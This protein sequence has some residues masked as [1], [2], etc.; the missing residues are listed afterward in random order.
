MS[1]IRVLDFQQSQDKRI[2]EQ[3]AQKVLG[4]DAFE[5]SPKL[6]E[7]LKYLLAQTLDGN[8][9]R[10]KQLTIAI[11]V[12]DRGAD[13]DHQTDPIVRIQAG[14]LRRA[15]ENYYLKDGRLDDVLIEIPKGRYQAE[16]SL[17]DVR[18][19][20][21]NPD[22]PEAELPSLLQP[23]LVVL[24]FQQIGSH[25]DQALFS[26]GFSEQLATE[27]ARFDHLQVVSLIGSGQAGEMTHAD[28]QTLIEKQDITFLVTGSVQY[29]KQ[30]MRLNV[31]LLMAQSQQQVWAE[32]FDCNMDTNELFDV[33]S[34]IIA[35][36]VAEIAST[37]G[38]IHR[39]LFASDNFQQAK[40]LSSYQATLKYR[41]YLLTLAQADFD[42]A[43]SAL[44]QTVAR[45][46]NFELAWAMLSVLY[47]DADKLNLGRVEGAVEKG[48][49]CA[50][51]AVELNAASQEA[52]MAL[53][54]SY[55]SQGNQ[56]GV[57]TTAPQVAQMN[58]NAAFQI[59][60]AGWTLCLAG[61]FVQGMELMTASKR[62]NPF[63][64]PWFSLA[65]SLNHLMQNQLHEAEKALDQFALHQ[66][67]WHPLMKTV[68]Q[69]EQGQIKQAQS[70]YKRLLE[71]A[72][73]FGQ[74]RMSIITSLISCPRI[75]KR[76]DKNL[77]T[78]SNRA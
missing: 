8:G 20:S 77:D 26:F 33:Q 34:Q 21:V 43:L 54:L 28:C 55:Q 23:R 52:Q 9:D 14:R 67:F 78:L 15:L 47:F 30:R 51:K 63:R 4:S 42:D 65:D 3:Q 48:V 29:H 25:P 31:R 37:F 5:Q 35:E 19:S 46:P 1:V 56:Q 76:I 16:F 6:H 50:N 39:Q 74:N 58:P 72:P 70:S 22:N 53:L 17:R 60:L 57:L 38:I 41:K 32:V 73:N 61:D 40:Q 45:E 64:P 12:F 18:E 71:M 27:L 62:L 44:E 10:L 75:L 13:F 69:V 24:P 49:R 68:L 59:G 2:I 66:V 7:L 11:D 36:I